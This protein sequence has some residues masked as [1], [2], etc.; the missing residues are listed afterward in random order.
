MGI[1]DSFYPPLLTKNY[2]LVQQLNTEPASVLVTLDPLDPPKTAPALVQLRVLGFRAMAHQG[3]GKV[4]Q[5]I[6][7]DFGELL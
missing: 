4:Y 2:F 5:R 6:V 1:I 7:A 3:F